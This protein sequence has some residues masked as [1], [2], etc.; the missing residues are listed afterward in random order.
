[1]QAA[2][3]KKNK[4]GTHNVVMHACLLIWSHSSRHSTHPQ[5]RRRGSPPPHGSPQ[6]RKSPVHYLETN[7]Y[8]QLVQKAPKG[9][10]SVVLLL[11]THDP[12]RSKPLAQH[13]WKIMEGY[14][15]SSSSVKPC[16]LCYR[17]YP[18][19]LGRILSQCEDITVQERDSR[20]KLTLS[21][22]CATVLVII[23]SKKQLSIFPEAHDGCHDMN[24]AVGG[25]ED[26]RRR[27]VG[28]ILGSSLGF[29]DNE[30]GK[31]EQSYTETRFCSQTFNSSNVAGS[32]KSGD[33]SCDHR[34]EQIK[35]F[36]MW[37]ERFFDGS[38]RRYRVQDW[39]EWQAA[40]Q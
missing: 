40:S 33:D 8:E 32:T 3:Q 17:A 19:L 26:L 30:D 5:Q 15:A 21:G 9:Q 28:Q 25:G 31:S 13:F 12:T 36:E 38:L 2:L 1:M 20:V 35:Q 23:G 16:F 4:R 6:K 22:K 18:Y 14:V 24:G 11:D 27:T 34:L 39:P 7:T 10:L 29:D 37:M